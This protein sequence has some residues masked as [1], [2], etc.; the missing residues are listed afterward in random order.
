MGC[1]RTPEGIKQSL[2]EEQS[3]EKYSVSL[4]CQKF[5][6]EHAGERI[7]QI[8][9]AVIAWKIKNRW[10]APQKSKLDDTDEIA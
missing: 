9:W 2:R 7:F 8:G 3:H 1:N 5:C 10:G 6:Q 4:I